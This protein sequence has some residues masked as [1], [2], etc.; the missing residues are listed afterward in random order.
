MQL[1]L[2]SKLL[3]HLLVSFTAPGL[4]ALYLC[5]AGGCFVCESIAVQQQKLATNLNSNLYEEGKKQ[6][7][8]R[9]DFFHLTSS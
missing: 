2:E 1:L 4:L 5:G 7:V 9:K 3:G 8:H 6:P